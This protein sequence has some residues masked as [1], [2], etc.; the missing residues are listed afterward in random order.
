MTAIVVAAFFKMPMNQSPQLSSG[1]MPGITLFRFSGDSAPRKPCFV[2]VSTIVAARD[3]PLAS[4]DMLDV[5]FSTTPVELAS[6]VQRWLN[7]APSSC[8]ALS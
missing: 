7:D 1:F 6:D 5:N 8:F 2:N 4:P 3:K